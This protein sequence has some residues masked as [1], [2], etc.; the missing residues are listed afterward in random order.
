MSKALD[1]QK[2]VAGEFFH[3]VVDCSKDGKCSCCG[4][5]CSDILPLLPTELSRLRAFV[6]KTHYKPHTKVIIPMGETYDGTCPFLNEDNKCDIYKI[7]PEICKM[8]KCW[9]NDLTPEKFKTLSPEVQSYYLKYYNK[10]PD[11]VSIRKEVFNEKV[12]F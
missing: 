7:R 10:H 8:F 3:K 2:A 11:V 9:Q 4:G 6:K 5:C 1:F 12:P